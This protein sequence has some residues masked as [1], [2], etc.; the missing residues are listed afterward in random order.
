[1]AM[2]TV[3]AMTIKAMNTF[4]AKT[5]YTLFSMSYSALNTIFLLTKLVA[6]EL[7]LRQ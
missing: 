2:V 5:S 7:I 3:L 4:L 1:M 6:G